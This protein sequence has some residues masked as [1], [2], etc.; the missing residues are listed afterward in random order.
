MDIETNI[1]NIDLSNNYIYEI[2]I[3]YDF[4]NLTNLNL[5]NTGDHRYSF[6]FF[7]YLSC[8]TNLNL[9]NNSIF[10][11]SFLKY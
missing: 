11:I 5:E 3:D 2:N 9:E 10:D 7:K 4:L 6:D 1:P 8:L